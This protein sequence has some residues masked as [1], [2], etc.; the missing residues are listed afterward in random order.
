ME[1]VTQENLT[2]LTADVPTERT[3]TEK[4]VTETIK[5]G[6]FPYLSDELDLGAIF[7]DDES[8]TFEEFQEKASD[9]INES[10]QVIYKVN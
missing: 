9:Y 3:V 2:S 10:V 5:A 7:Y 8:M 1:N 6:D 4:L